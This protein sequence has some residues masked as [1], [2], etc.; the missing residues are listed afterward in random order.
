MVARLKRHHTEP[1]SHEW[2]QRLSALAR[3]MR[4][5]GRD[6]ISMRVSVNIRTAAVIG[7]LRPVILVP[8]SALTGLAPHQMEAVLAHELA[9]IR[10]HDYLVNLL[11]SVVETLFFYHP[12]VWYLS[13]RVRLERENCCDDDAVAVVGD[14]VTYAGALTDLELLR[15]GVP[16][17]AMAANG[18]SLLRRVQRLL[19]PRSEDAAPSWSTATGLL[20]L[21]VVFAVLATAHGSIAAGLQPESS[22]VISSAASI[23]NDGQWPTPPPPPPAP[24]VAR[25][26]I[27][28]PCLDAAGPPAPPEPPNRRTARHAAGAAGTAGTVRSVERRLA[29]ATGSGARPSL[30]HRRPARPAP[31]PGALGRSAAT[32]TRGAGSAR[33]RAAGRCRAR[34]QPCP[35]RAPPAPRAFGPMPAPPAPAP[36]RVPSARCPRRPRQPPRR[37]PVPPAPAAPAA[38][39]A[40]PP[41]AAPRA[42]AQP[43]APERRRRR[44]HRAPKAAP[45]EASTPRPA[46]QPTAPPAPPQAATAVRPSA[47]RAPP[48]PPPA[49]GG[50]E[51]AMNWIGSWFDFPEGNHFTIRDGNRRFSVRNHGDVD[52]TDNDT[53]IRAISDGGYLIIEEKIGWDRTRVDIRHDADG[54]LQR[55]FYRNGKAVAYEPEGRAWLAKKVPDLV[56]NTGFG[57]EAR[58]RRIHTAGGPAAVLAE[59]TKIK[60]SYVKRLYL[61]QAARPAAPSRGRC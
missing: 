52:V 39:P 31:G 12:A 37:A 8:A 27:R 1:A 3:R 59:V 21:A 10:R 43:A 41:P 29:G 24:R 32:A 57:A 36:R 7:W 19:A 20:T 42:P 60:N 2:Q 6:A 55:T 54:R 61:T 18:G 16:A 51:R 47:A 34:P 23:D 11:Q 15:Q 26:N 5:R 44:R 17:L 25:T 4:V 9:H 38:P 35:R 56:R 14:P 49:E 45:V 46:A 13:R 50:I 33:R 53:D 48:P 22:G 58:V 40:P 30:R 28:A